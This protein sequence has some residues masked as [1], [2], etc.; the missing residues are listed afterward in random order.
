M[1]GFCCF[2]VLFLDLKAKWETF[3]K[4]YYT[5]LA[6][7]PLTTQKLVHAPSGK[8]ILFSHW[9]NQLVN[10]WMCLIQRPT[11]GIIEALEKIIG[12]GFIVQ[13]PGMHSWQQSYKCLYL[14]WFDWV[15]LGIHKSLPGR[16]LVL[17]PWVFW[18]FLF[19]YPLSSGF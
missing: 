12:P 15:A 19:W 14:C 3:L 4:F 5:G 10:A 9:V 7:F 13:N 11:E 6:E 16:S 2:L 8:L 1:V 17:S 18:V